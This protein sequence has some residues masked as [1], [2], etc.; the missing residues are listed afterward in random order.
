[1]VDLL[2]QLLNLLEVL[3]DQALAL[4]TALDLN[5]F[6]VAFLLTERLHFGQHPLVLLDL[7]FEL[8]AAGPLG[9]S[10]EKRC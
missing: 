8:L 2:T 6:L 7:R 5:L 4:D 10:L 1:L 3:A 9:V